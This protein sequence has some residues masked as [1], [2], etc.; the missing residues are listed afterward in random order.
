MV[1][2]KDRDTCKNNSKLRGLRRKDLETLDNGRW[3]N[4]EVF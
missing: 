1:L 2:Q 3:L 4:D